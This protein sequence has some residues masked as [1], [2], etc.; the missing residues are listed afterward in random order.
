VHTHTHT[1][2][3][4]CLCQKHLKHTHMHTHTQTHTQYTFSKVFT[5]WALQTH[6]SAYQLTFGAKCT[7]TTKTLHTSPKSDSCCRNFSKCSLSG[8]LLCHSKYNDLKNRQLEAL[9]NAY[10]MCNCILYT[11]Y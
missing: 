7:K 5:Q 6:T 1:L 8:R 4:P 10:I 9:Q 3:L 11:V 2:P